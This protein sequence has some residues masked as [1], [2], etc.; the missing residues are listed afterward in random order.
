MFDQIVDSIA[1]FG[2]VQ[3][4]AFVFNVLY[5]ILAA[6]ENI[7]CWFFGFVGV[8]FLFV[9]YLDARLY[10]D[11]LLQVFYMGMSVY[12]WISWSKKTGE[13]LP[14]IRASGRDHAYYIVAGITGTFILGFIFTRFQAALPYVDA[15]T[16]AYAVVTTF[17]VARKILENWIYWILIDSVCIIVYLDRNLPLIAVLFFIYTVLA[18]NG[19]LAWN[20]KIAAQDL[21]V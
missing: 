7:W 16:S 1:S 14:I 19:W 18:I 20:R 8:S 17:M 5:V 13:H 10:S 11:A 3:W 12:G 4:L 21:E 9:I 2:W 15:F 6:R